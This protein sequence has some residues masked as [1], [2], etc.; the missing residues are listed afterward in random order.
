MS[1]TTDTASSA[2]SAT[3]AS[4]MAQ[5]SAYVRDPKNWELAVRR[6][7][8]LVGLAQPILDLPR[9]D[10]T[11][12]EVLAALGGLKDRVVR[13]SGPKMVAEYLMQLWN[14]AR[15][16]FVFLDTSAASTGLLALLPRVRPFFAAGGKLLVCM[17]VKAVGTKTLDEMRAWAAALETEAATT[18]GGGSCKF[19]FKDARSCIPDNEILMAIPGN[20]VLKGKI[21]GDMSAA[22]IG[23]DRLGVTEP[24]ASTAYR[25]DI[26]ASS[27]A[28]A[29]F[30][31]LDLSIPDELSHAERYIEG[32]FNH[33]A[34][35]SRKGHLAFDVAALHEACALA[36]Q[37]R[38]PEELHLQAARLDAKARKREARAAFERRFFETYHAM[39]GVKFDYDGDGVEDAGHS[40]EDKD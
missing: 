29:D 9:N 5:A 4:L 12:A 18:G 22:S 20:L 10:E 40:E 37:M 35:H 32:L 27:T 38:S 13:G 25:R 21:S 11:Y 15:G 3:N 7:G 19:I 2:L 17:P 30:T 33:W 34:D 14:A 36:E 16:G 24:D 1:D 8:G 28:P 39:N 26:P 23:T 6:K 31:L